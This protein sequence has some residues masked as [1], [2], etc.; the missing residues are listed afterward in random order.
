MS[1]PLRLDFGDPAK[2]PITLTTDGTL[3]GLADAINDPTTATGLTAR[4]VRTGADASG[5]ATYG[6]VVTADKTGAASQFTLTYD[7]N[8][9]AAGTHLA[10]EAPGARQGTDARISLGS[11]LSLTSSTNTFTDVAPGV[12]LTLSDAATLNKA[13]TVTVAQDSSGVKSS[14]AALVKQVN[15]LLTKIDTQSANATGSGSTATPAGVLAGDA[16]VR[17]V[18]SALI[19][20]VFGSDNSSMASLGIQTDRTGMLVFDSAAFD[21]AYAADP[22]GTAA[23]F[24]SATKDATTGAVTKP[25]GW[26][27]RLAAVATGA[28][29]SHTGTITSAITGRKSTIDRLGDDIA[30]WDD[31]LALRRTSLQQTYTALETALSGLQSQGNWLA[32]QIAHLPSSS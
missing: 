18:R 3:Q 24:T 17:S 2:A 5:A 23:K 28:S 21:K 10:Q 30:A 11:G 27:A 4:V 7:D 9:G 16:T 13:T 1:G 29:D 31:R 14:V 19:D 15:D 32:G 20:S 12:S 6:L 8:G 26:A 22:A 25:D